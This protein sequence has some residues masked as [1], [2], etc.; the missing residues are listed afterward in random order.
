MQNFIPVVIDIYPPKILVLFIYSF[1]RKCQLKSCCFNFIASF[2]QL[3]PFQWK[4]SLKKLDRPLKVSIKMASGTF[5]RVLQCFEDFETIFAFLLN[6]VTNSLFRSI[7]VYAVCFSRWR[8]ADFPLICCSKQWFLK[9]ASKFGAHQ[10]LNPSSSSCLLVFLPKV[11]LIS[12]SFARKQAFVLGR[13]GIRNLPISVAGR[14][15]SRLLYKYLK[16]GGRGRGGANAV[17]NSGYFPACNAVV[18]LKI[19]TRPGWT[20]TKGVAWPRKQIRTKKL[21]LS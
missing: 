8:R 14:S 1:V 13:S 15:G 2:W 21:L 7:S 3:P 10:N 6:L 18:M 16:S 20:R 4:L 12:L 11:T 5:F 9:P 17:K 19:E